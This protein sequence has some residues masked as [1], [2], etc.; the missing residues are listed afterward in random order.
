MFFFLHKINL[1]RQSSPQYL[2]VW[3]N[4]AHG[5]PHTEHGE[6]PERRGAE[7]AAEADGEG[8]RHGQRNVPQRP[9]RPSAHLRQTDAP[10]RPSMQPDGQPL[11]TGA[12]MW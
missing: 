4:A 6:E 5:P 10:R 1:H 8:G 11:G 3:P 2:W 7:E 9:L 12:P